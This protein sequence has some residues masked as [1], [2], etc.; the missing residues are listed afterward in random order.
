MPDKI[1]SICVF[2]GSLS[3]TSPRYEETA[4]LVGRTL[5]ERGIRLVYGG[6]SVG[7]MGVMADSCVEAGGEVTGVITTYLFDKELGHPGISKLEIVETML[8]RKLRMAELSD[9]FI[10]LPGGIGTLDELFEMLTWSR[11]S[12]HDK[13]SGL[14]NV[15]GFYDELISF[16]LKTQVEGGFISAADANN[17]LISE[18]VDDILSQLDRAVGSTPS[19]RFS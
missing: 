15:E 5:A 3:G 17:L 7:L 8:D 9:A 13:P 4:R 6:G 2:C 12:I 10:S 16:T 19:S 11:L 14:I 18:N 1:S